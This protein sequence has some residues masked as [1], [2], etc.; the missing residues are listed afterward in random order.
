MMV[1]L[2]LWVA[3]A[4]VPHATRRARVRIPGPAHFFMRAVVSIS[5]YP[6]IS[7]SSMFDI[8]EPTWLRR[9][10]CDSLQGSKTRGTLLTASRYTARLCKGRIGVEYVAN[11]ADAATR[12][13]WITG[14]MLRWLLRL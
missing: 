4:S 13:L 7:A 11:T 5:V 1:D 9:S 3:K 12:L 2:S 14:G 8:Q 10:R 6:A